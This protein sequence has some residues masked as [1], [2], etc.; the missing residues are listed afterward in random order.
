VDR[1]TILVGKT[2]STI[3]KYFD[4]LLSLKT[5][6][7]YK[8]EK[9]TTEKG[10]LDLAVKFSTDDESFYKCIGITAT[11]QR[12]NGKEYCH[13]Q[14]IY[15]QV[16]DAQF[17]LSYIKDNFTYVSENIWEIPNAEILGLRTTAEYK[18]VDNA[19]VLFFDLRGSKK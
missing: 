3:T 11:F 7:Y 12:V 5:N 18:K 15:G 13:A 8:I 2:D 17:Y 16:A 6:P 4:S 10:D 19:F 14:T 1:V 9:G